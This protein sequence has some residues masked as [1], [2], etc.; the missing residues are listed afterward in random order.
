MPSVVRLIMS[1]PDGQPLSLG[2]GF[3]VADGVVV[4]N[5]HVVAGASHGR[6]KLVEQQH[7]YSIAGSLGVSEESDLV[8]L[9]VTGLRADALPLARDESVSI[10]DE[11]YVIGN[12]SG[13]EGT[14]STGI[15]SGIR[16]I[17]QRKVLQIT[18]P[19]SAGSSGGPVLNDKAEVIGIAVATL[20]DGQ[21][22]NFAV[23][24]SNLSLLLSKSA[25]ETPLSGL[26][27][28]R[29]HSGQPQT[30]PPTQSIKITDRELR[31]AGLGLAFSI[32]NTLPDAIDSVS[33]QFNF[34]DAAGAPFDSKE[35]T[36]S[37]RISPGSAAR[38]DSL[39]LGVQV[40]LELIKQRIGARRFERECAP[41]SAGRFGVWTAESDLDFIEIRVLGFRVLEK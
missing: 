12:P 4:T 20:K 21:N 3:V 41:V 27:D 10:G 19:I 35:A 38:I 9:R 39:R 14:I 18:A 32:R 6:A 25:A 28:G 26:G 23:P 31:C 8:L 16:E 36:Y 30:G 11:V 2:S 22:L 40:P 5:L 34:R 15:V 13:L 33:L 17:E 29:T 24:V 37:G 1:G 7:E